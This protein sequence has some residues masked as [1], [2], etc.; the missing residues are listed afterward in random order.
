M[1]VS[2]K[3]NGFKTGDLV[4][5][6]GGCWL[7]SLECLPHDAPTPVQ[8]DEIVKEGLPLI[9]MKDIP[10]D[11]WS[12]WMR[13]SCDAFDNGKMK[14]CLVF[15]EGREWVVYEKDITKNRP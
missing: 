13:E 9:F 1:L 10:K 6:L 5:T 2:E 3:S 4:W 11:Q 14:W 8:S 7:Y 12:V 15:Y